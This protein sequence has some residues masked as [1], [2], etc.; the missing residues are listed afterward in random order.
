MTNFTAANELCTEVMYNFPLSEDGHT[1]ECR[2]DTEGRYWMEVDRGPN[3]LPF[4][5]SFADRWNT[6]SHFYATDDD[7]RLVACT[8]N[9][10]AWAWT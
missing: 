6:G 10:Y 3:G 4:R 5:A 8:K 1:R 9:D 7:G 2:S